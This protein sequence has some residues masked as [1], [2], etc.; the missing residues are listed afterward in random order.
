[1]KLID[2][3]MQSMKK[4]SKEHSFL[5]IP[6]VIIWAA[7][8]A[9]FY[10]MCGIEPLLLDSPKL[11][12]FSEWLARSGNILYKLF[13]MIGDWTDCQG[14]RSLTGGAALVLSGLV[15]HF[16]LRKGSKAKMY[17]V[18]APLGVMPQIVATGFV[19]V[20]LATMLFGSG[21][22][23]GW[24][25]TFLPCCTIP[26]AL[27][28]T[29]GAHWSVWLT[30]GVLGALIQYPISVFANDLAG[31]L[32]IPPI[33]TFTLLAVGIGGIIITEIYRLLPW[34]KAA[35]RDPAKRI[36]HPYKTI[37]PP[38]PEASIGWYVRRCL[39]DFTDLLFFGNEWVA[40][41]YIAGLFLSW[42]LNPAHICY[43]VPN[44]FP[45]MLCG[46]LLGTS[47][48]VFIWYPKYKE[49][50]TFN[51]FCTN[52]VMAV[53]PLFFGLSGEPAT[54]RIGFLIVLAVIASLFCPPFC[55]WLTKI[56]AQC[57]SRRYEGAC[58]GVIAAAPAL[59]ICITIMT[60]VAK[61]LLAL[62]L[63]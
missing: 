2:V 47:L 29:Y 39:T 26:A 19:G 17:P 51:T 5:I 21:L 12:S 44:L 62:G 9:L 8:I 14:F 50:G 25:P 37:N 42:L 31:K 24:I 6:L 1:M 45:A 56:F 61:F 49:L 10:W 13:W 55:A 16:I 33:C 18:A 4:L 27:V 38:V 43:G 40:V 58:A 59:G 11:F 7:S 41:C 3:E 48:S 30:G 32:A 23:Q 36:F 52:E 57:T 46:M 15:V 54:F 22:K 60:L 20:G 34:C 63:F 53:V 28:L 35:V